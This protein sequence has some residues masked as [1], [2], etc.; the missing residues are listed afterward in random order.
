MP[1]ADGGATAPAQAQPDMMEAGAPLATPPNCEGPAC[2]EEAGSMFVPTLLDGGGL[3]A[4]TGLA[5]DAALD[6]VRRTWVGRYAARSALF[7]FDDPLKSSATLLSI[8]TIEPDESGG[9]IMEEEMCFYEGS[10]NFFY[11]GQLQ[12]TYTDTRGSTKLNY[13]K[14]NFN[15]ELLKL[16]IGYGPTPS[17]CRPGSTL[18]AGPTRPWL[19][20]T[21]DCPGTEDTPTSV[22]DCRVTDQDNDGDPGATFGASI[23]TQV[24]SYH[25][26]QEE[27]VALRNGFRRNDRL[28]AD[29]FFE[30]TTR[31]LDCTVDGRTTAA[32]SCPSGVPKPCPSNHNKVELVG[33]PN[34]T[35]AQVIAMESALFL[36]P[37]PNYPQS[38]PS[39][40]S[41]SAALGL[42][43]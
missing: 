42:E 40:V 4:G 11:T 12:Y 14:E 13:D 28:Y 18:S 25:T 29:R 30:E 36:S 9:L 17:E 8:I 35:C 43:F 6:E 7:A 23:D 38:C 16:Q 34:I 3:E 37:L 2:G 22:R 33:A 10:W 1:D 15:S 31:V 19:T 20:S 41:G 24:I 39:E 27:R 26:T 5:P 21:C 32:S